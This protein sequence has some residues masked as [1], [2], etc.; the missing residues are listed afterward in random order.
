M[1]PLPPPDLT[2]R[3]DRPAA[4]WTEALPLGNGRIGAMHFGGPDQERFQLNEDTL[5]SG[6]P[7]KGDNPGARAVLPEI[8]KALFEGRWK[9]ADALARKMQGPYTESYMPLGDLRLDFAHGGAA[10][11][12]T[13]QLDLDEAVS[14]VSYTANG[15]RFRRE[16][17]V[18]HPAQALVVRLTADRKGSISFTARMDSRLR[19]RTRAEG[20]RVE[21]LGRA[22]KH[23]RPSYLGGKDAVHYDD[24]PDGEGMRF[25]AV[26]DARAKGGSVAVDGSTLVVKNADEVVLVLT[27]GTTFRG[28]DQPNGRDDREALEKCLQTLGRSQIPFANLR[29]A[30]LADHR[31]L[32]RR[33][34]LDLGGSDAARTRSTVERIRAYN[35]DEDPGLATLMFQFGR[36]LM[37]AS[38]RPGTQAANLQG[39]WND[40]VRPPWSS[41]YT[42]NINAQMN[43]WP[44]ETTNLAECHEPLFALTRALAKSGAE[45]A[46][47][48]Y[49]AGGWVAHHNA[50]IWA[51]STPVGEGS[52]DPIW[53]NWTMG[54]AWLALHLYDHYEFS[55]DERFLR[56]AY[57]VLKGAAEFCLDW[58]IPDARPNAPRDAQ[59]RPYLLT[60]PS[61]SPEIS[62]IPPGGKDVSTSIG[63][64]MDLQIIRELFE[65]VA[66]AS[67]RLGIDREFAQRVA[68]ARARIL[69]HQIGSRGQLQEWADDYR[70][71]DVHHRHVSHLFAAYPANDITP[72]ATPALATAVR[73]S[74]DLRGDAATGWGMGWRLC[75]WARLRDSARA[76]GMVKYLLQLVDTSDTNYKGGG[77]VYANLFDAHP[78]FQIDGNFAYT[79][80]VAEMLLQ[81]HEGRLH[82]LPALPDKWATGRVSGLRG[83]G[84]FEVDLE[85][86]DGRVVRG[87]VRSKVGGPCRIKS[88]PIEV[89]SRGR[90]VRTTDQGG[91]ISFETKP[92]AVYE[93]RLR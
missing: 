63:A 13:R 60:A 24:A 68:Q 7:R 5:W 65:H 93:L 69:P 71:S 50:D 30:H 90:K 45:T 16:A 3:Y 26:L 19:F 25:A 42:L 91:V 28:A 2:L 33:V 49:G 52:G 72:D 76:F 70:E 86:A 85:W 78:P 21:L 47:V 84:G 8:R 31:R 62:F 80:G 44:A 29:R 36:Y 87:R 1:L 59:G 6:E 53:A 22:P 14:S 88:T 20:S 17:F 54:G 64:S 74:M 46:K 23:V 43:Y 10:T 9:D 58:L 66:D 40:E 39:I 34:A 11:D 15:V 48:N 41:N 89:W 37:I 57:P 92:G 51:H 27:A 79:A 35:Q 55:R 75:L 18:S 81:S 67:E 73:R 77:G 56:E 32:F 82:F 12:Y 83:R 61:V 38:S 4:V